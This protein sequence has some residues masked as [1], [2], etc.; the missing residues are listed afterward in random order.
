[1][2]TNLSIRK[3]MI[4][5]KQRFV[6]NCSEVNTTL[7]VETWDIETKQEGAT[8]DFDHPAWDIASSFT[9]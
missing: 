6:D 8:Q 1:M 4:A 7:M 3:W 5:N 2:P 9:R